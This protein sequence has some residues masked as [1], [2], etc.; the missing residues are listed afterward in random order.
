MEISQQR[1]FLYYFSL[2]GWGAGKIQKELTDA[3]GS[4]VYL[5]AQISRW[6]ARFSTGDI[7]CLDEARTGRPLSILERPLEH[8]LA[9]F[10]FASACTIAM[11]FNESHSIV[12]EGF[13]QELGLR[14]F[15]RRCV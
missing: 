9:K 4:D 1:V 7:S 6:L 11:H 5:Q 8:F 10:P 3:L 12:K 13:S 2:K 15:S 14:Q